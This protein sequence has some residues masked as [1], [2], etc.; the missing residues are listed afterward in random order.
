MLPDCIENIRDMVTH[1]LLMRF[2][3]RLMVNNVTFGE[4]LIKTVKSLMY[5]LAS[6]PPNPGEMLRLLS[7]SL[8]EC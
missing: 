7:D 1:F 3:S 2:S 4:Q 5:S 8:I 6:A